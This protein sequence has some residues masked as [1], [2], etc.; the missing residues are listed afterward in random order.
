MYDPR[1]VSRAMQTWQQASLAYTRMWLSAS[2][3]IWTRSMMMALG[4]MTPKEAAQMVFE[5]P[6]AFAR[7]AEKAAVAMAT[8]SG[9]AAAALA[10]I[11]PIEAKT[12][13]NARRLRSRSR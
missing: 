10:S 6:T 8:S 5:K 13:S 1:A 11:R 9:N 7:A 2:E 4:T 12:R 3:V